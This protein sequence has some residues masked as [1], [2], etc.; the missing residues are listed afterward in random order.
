MLPT[1]PSANL[2]RS[3]ETALLNWM[4]D[5]LRRVREPE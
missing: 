3:S 4:D 2:K 1:K 5:A